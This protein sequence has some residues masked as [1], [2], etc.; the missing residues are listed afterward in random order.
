VECLGILVPV[1]FFGVA[2]MSEVLTEFTIGQRAIDNP[3]II[4][5]QF[6]LPA[7]LIT[8]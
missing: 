7:A 1:I 8:K 2:I 3:W 4:S 5:A 6:L